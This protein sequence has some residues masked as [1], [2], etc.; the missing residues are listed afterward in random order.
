[1]PYFFFF[2]RGPPRLRLYLDSTSFSNVRVAVIY[3]KFSCP[4]LS[5]LAGWTA[6]F[7]FCKLDGD[8]RICTYQP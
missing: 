5:L 2:F 3:P 7:F 4:P 1:M 6:G 8:R